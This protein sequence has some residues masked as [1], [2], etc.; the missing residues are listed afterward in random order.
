MTVL[1]R[2]QLTLRDPISPG[3]MR[4]KDFRSWVFPDIRFGKPNI[5]GFSKS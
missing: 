2:A 4:F 3:F 1:L 5:S